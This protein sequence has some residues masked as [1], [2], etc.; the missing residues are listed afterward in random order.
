METS[1]LT[2][3]NE[4]SCF[5]YLS[6]I[7]LDISHILKPR[8]HLIEDWNDFSNRKVKPIEIRNFF[9]FFLS[10][11]LSFV[12][13][14]FYLLLNLLFSFFIHIFKW[15][16]FNSLLSFLFFYPLFFLLFFFFI[17]FIFCSSDCYPPIHGADHTK[18]I[19][20][21]FLVQEFISGLFP[22]QP[23]FILSKAKD[24]VVFEQVTINLKYCSQ[25]NLFFRGGP[26]QLSTIVFMQNIE[27][28]GF[29]TTN[30]PLSILEIRQLNVWM[31][32]SHLSTI[33]LEPLILCLVDIF[34]LF[35]RNFDMLQD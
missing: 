20:F 24:I 26:Q 3:N 9:L 7:I 13:F 31:F 12:F 8:V 6:H 29:S 32:Y 5:V 27:N 11:K 19:S 35:V 18:Y 1:W 23:F 10:S 34:T 28:Y 16:L 25:H 17:L 2:I 21:E 15:L 14:L 22:T 30:Y 33:F 4:L